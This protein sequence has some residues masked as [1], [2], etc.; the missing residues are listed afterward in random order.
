M[1]VVVLT[2]A[3][4]S[5]ESGI[6]TFRDANGLWENHRIEDV[7]TPEAWVR[8][9]ELVLK[10]YNQ[11]R[12]QLRDVKPN[13]AHIAL[14]ELEQKI[15]TVII[16]QNVDDLHERAG[17]RNVIHL[18]GELMYARS[19]RFPELRYRLDNFLLEKGDTCERGAQL[20]PDIVWFGEPVPMI[21]V[22]MGEMLDA[23]AVFIVGTSLEVYP[24]AGLIDF[25][26]PNVPV[27][28]IDPNRHAGMSN[29]RIRVIQE[30]ATSGVPK[31]ISQLFSLTP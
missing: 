25:A 11:R 6:S 17:S 19:T 14:A 5:A 10:F 24:A 13:A 1:K 23:D 9:P 28:V 12:L 27:W 31:A 15:D 30:P 29:A 21:D 4:I 18:H 16:T 22:A 26:P 8:N 2:G 3:G 7:A 20:R